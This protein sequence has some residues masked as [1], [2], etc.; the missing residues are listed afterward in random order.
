M[1]FINISSDQDNS[2]EGVVHSVSFGQPVLDES[3]QVLPVSNQLV[4]IAKLGSAHVLFKQRGIVLDYLSPL[5]EL[6][7]CRKHIIGFVNYLELYAKGSDKGEV[8]GERW[9]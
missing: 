3:G 1:T 4:V 8:I 2:I 6:L 9:C 5:P 7:E